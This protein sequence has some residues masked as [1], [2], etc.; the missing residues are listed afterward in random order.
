MVPAGRDNV[1][2]GESAGL[3]IAIEVGQRIGPPVGRI[4][5][6]FVERMQADFRRLYPHMNEDLGGN[7]F[8]RD[9]EAEV[10]RGCT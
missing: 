7:D 9:V 3:G 4:N 6:R 2:S 8:D 5:P 10:A 1:A